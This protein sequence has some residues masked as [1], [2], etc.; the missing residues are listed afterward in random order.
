MGTSY[1]QD[2]IIWEQVTIGKHNKGTS[3]YREDIIWEQVTIRKA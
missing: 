1:Y 2:G 3:Y